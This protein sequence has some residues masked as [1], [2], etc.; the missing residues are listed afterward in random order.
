VTL[1]NEPN[2]HVSESYVRAT[3]PPQRRNLLLA[4]KVYRNLV[5]AHGR[6]YAAMKRA[7][8]DIQV[9]IAFALSDIRPA[10]RRN[11]LDRAVVGL[12]NYV[13]NWWYIDRI[14]AKLDFIGVNYYFTSYITWAGTLKN[15]PSP[16][17]DLGWYMEP[18]RLQQVLTAVWRRY[19][20]PVMVTENGLAD[21]TDAHR[22]WWLEQTMQ[23][24]RGALA[25]GVNVRGYLHWSLL[26]NFEWEQGF[27]PRF[28]LI[29]VDRKT[30]KRTIR[31]SAKWLAIYIKQTK[32]EDA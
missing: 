13:A 30:M 3:R 17:S 29:T 24:L 18:A 28:G 10:R 25:V 9:G 4:L 32:R 14:C 1:L 16:V 31:P 26:D 7:K 8:P 21:A 2:V 20:K 12:A 11:M 27:W 22:Q 5:R 15:P 19:R 23:A 6:G